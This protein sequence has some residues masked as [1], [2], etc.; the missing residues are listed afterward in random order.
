MNFFLIW[1]S[2][3][4][5]SSGGLTECGIVFRKESDPA[6]GLPC[7]K[8]L[9][10]DAHIFQGKKI[11]LM[12]GIEP[13]TYALRVRRSTDWATLAYLRYYTI[14]FLFFNHYFKKINVAWFEAFC[15]LYVDARIILVKKRGW[16]F[17]IST[18]NKYYFPVGCVKI[19]F[20]W[21]ISCVVAFSA[22]T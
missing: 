4:H 15:P 13:L 17:N 3:L 16:I 11:K 1:N 8:W 2:V 7:R 20:T 18:L 12:R 6:L 14:N 21:L 22:G 10:F 19:D 9:S 5:G